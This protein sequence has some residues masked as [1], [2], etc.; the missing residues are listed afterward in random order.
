MINFCRRCGIFQHKRSL[1][2]STNSN[3]AHG[4]K[5]SK[6]LHTSLGPISR[7]PY[8]LNNVTQ[9]EQ[10][11]QEGP[12]VTSPSLSPS[13]RL[14]ICMVRSTT[15]MNGLFCLVFWCLGRL[16][17]C[18]LRIDCHCGMLKLLGYLISCKASLLKH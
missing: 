8:A 10:D 18:C 2:P 11:Y 4:Q 9:V 14:E 7:S 5:Y 17:D 13:S 3:L 12:Y 15:A 1:N 16:I 6:E